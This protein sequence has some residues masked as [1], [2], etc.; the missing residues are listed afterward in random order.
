MKFDIAAGL[1]LL[2]VGLPA[3]KSY[4]LLVVARYDDENVGPAE[5]IYMLV[6]LETFGDVMVG[7]MFKPTRKDVARL[8]DA[9]VGFKEKPV[10]D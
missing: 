7:A 3:K 6:E 9:N 2:F 5:T 1:V 4:R 10:R 8:V